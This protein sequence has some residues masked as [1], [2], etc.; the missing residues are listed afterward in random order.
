M[1]R[2]ATLDAALLLA[3]EARKPL[4]KNRIGRGHKVRPGAGD[5]GV[6]RGERCR[7]D[8]LGFRLRGERQRA[9]R[10]LPM[11]LV[12]RAPGASERGPRYA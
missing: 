5:R 6:P 1:P 3:C 12:R 11:R 9:E 7:V 10:G 4:T 2:T 8:A